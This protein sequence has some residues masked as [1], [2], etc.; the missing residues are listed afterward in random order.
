MIRGVKSA[1]H[2][3]HDEAIT[4]WLK[5][6]LMLTFI[7]ILYLIFII[8]LFKS[9][10]ITVPF[11]TNIVY[12]IIALINSVSIFLTK[13]VMLRTTE[14]LVN[15]VTTRQSQVNASHSLSPSPP[16]NFMPDKTTD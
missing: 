5:L 2:N 10:N 7:N 11:I 14:L 6:Y 16:L 12:K 8:L 1:K 3:N 15:V 4:V 9:T 13:T